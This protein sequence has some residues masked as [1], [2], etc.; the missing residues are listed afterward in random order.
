MEASSPAKSQIQFGCTRFADVNPQI[1]AYARGKANHL[2]AAVDLLRHFVEEVWAFEAQDHGDPEPTPALQH[3]NWQA[4]DLRQYQCPSSEKVWI[5]DEHATVWFM[6]AE[7]GAQSV[8]GHWQAYQD[9]AAGKWW[10]N[11][12]SRQLYFPGAA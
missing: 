11:E 3:D 8:C 4:L 12:T 7:N 1:H 6:P 9:E 2:S 10:C 5:S